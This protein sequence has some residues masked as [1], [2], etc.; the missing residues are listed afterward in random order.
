MT[1]SF[2]RAGSI[3]VQ[4]QALK[5]RPVEIVTPSPEAKQ[6]Q[7][8]NPLDKA[9]VSAVAKAGWEQ[10]QREVSRLSAALQSVS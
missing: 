8:R 1:M 4:R 10:A 5:G 7:G 9:V 3:S 2:K 6:A